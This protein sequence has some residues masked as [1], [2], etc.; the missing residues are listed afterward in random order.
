[1]VKS[2]AISEFIKSIKP[3]SAAPL[4]KWKS[5]T[6]FTD[7]RLAGSNGT[8]SLVKVR[9]SDSGRDELAVVGGASNSVQLFTRGSQRAGK[10]VV[11]DSVLSLETASKTIVVLPMRLNRDALSDLVVLTEGSNVPNVVM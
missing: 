8:S 2:E 9:V 10:A 1:R 3:V 5:E 7:S 11:N 6:L 4:A